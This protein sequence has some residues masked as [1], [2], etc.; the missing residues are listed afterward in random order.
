M[1]QEPP[2][3]QRRV[4]LAHVHVRVSI[5]VFAIA[6][7]YRFSLELFVVSEWVV[8]SKS[9][10]VDSQRL[11][12]AVAEQESHGRFVSGF[13]S[14]DVSL[15]AATINEC[16]NRWLVLV[17]ASTTAFREATRARLL[18]TLAAFQ[19]RRHIEFVDR[20]CEV[21]CWWRTF[22]RFSGYRRT[23]VA[24]SNCGCHRLN[25]GFYRLGANLATATNNLLPKSERWLCT[26]LM[27]IF[28]FET[29]ENLIQYSLEST[30]SEGQ[31]AGSL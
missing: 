10:G 13:R 16:E 15:I 20:S 3:R 24:G 25:E 30:L 7:N 6:V 23:D 17:I 19:P 9:V 22:L 26:I 27:W 4:A 28:I 12:P 5:D 11:L 2:S 29:G 18:V 8:R 31:F 1:R 14:D 21:R